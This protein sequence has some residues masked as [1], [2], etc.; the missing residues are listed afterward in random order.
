M[1]YKILRPDTYVS[2]DVDPFV[3]GIVMNRSNPISNICTVC[4]FYTA[5]HLKEYKKC[6]KANMP[7]L[8]DVLVEYPHGKVNVNTDRYYPMNGKEPAE[9]KKKRR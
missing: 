8:A 4:T 5:D 2:N 9:L 3:T 7:L 6:A 1:I